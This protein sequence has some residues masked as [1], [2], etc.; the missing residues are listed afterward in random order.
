MFPG[1]C[2]VIGRVTGVPVD[3]FPL[4]L[5]HVVHRCSRCR[6]LRADRSSPPLSGTISAGRGTHARIGKILLPILS[7]ELARQ[8]L[9]CRRVL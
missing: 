5:Y 1:S 8:D 2:A 4:A 3:R 9:R 6:P 7:H